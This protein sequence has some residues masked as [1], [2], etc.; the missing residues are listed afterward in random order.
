MLKHITIWSTLKGC[1]LRVIL[2]NLTYAF[3][4]EGKVTAEQMRA[5][6]DRANSAKAKRAAETLSQLG[7][8]GKN[9]TPL[10]RINASGD[11]LWEAN[12]GDS[13]PCH[14]FPCA[15]WPSAWACAARPCICHVP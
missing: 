13:L 10:M 4:R 2:A 5:F 14:C 3:T 1:S 8:D 12:P 15:G 9:P 7:P 11:Q 6:I